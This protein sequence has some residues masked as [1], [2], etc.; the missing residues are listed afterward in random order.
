LGYV[1]GVLKKKSSLS[2]LV[3]LEKSEFTAKER[4]TPRKFMGFCRENGF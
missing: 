4:R 3:S 1:K 2:M